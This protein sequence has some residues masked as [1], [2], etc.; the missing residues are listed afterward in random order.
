MDVPRL[1]IFADRATVPCGGG[2]MDDD[3][4]PTE[5]PN[6]GSRLGFIMGGVSPLSVSGRDT[7][8]LAAET[9]MSTILSSSVS[10]HK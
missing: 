2:G 1:E 10:S 7:R 3:C 6:D 8:L 4:D 5:L 9:F